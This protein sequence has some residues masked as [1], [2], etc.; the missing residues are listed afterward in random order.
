MLDCLAHPSL[1]L[2][3]PVPRPRPRPASDPRRSRPRLGAT[4]RRSA[5]A[6]TLA[7][8]VHGRRH[9]GVDS[10]TVADRHSAGTHAASGGNDRAQAKQA[11]IARVPAQPVLL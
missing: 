9:A 3:R 6:K 4:H 8:P 2:H 7:R 11:R 10:Q 5:Q 1:C